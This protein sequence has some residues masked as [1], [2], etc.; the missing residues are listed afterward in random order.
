MMI[1]KV[2]VVNKVVES[3]LVNDLVSSIEMIQDNKN[4]IVVFFDR[5][6][7]NH[8]LVMFKGNSDCYL[9]INNRK[10]DDFNYDSLTLPREKRFTWTYSGGQG[11]LATYRLLAIVDD[12]IKH[13]GMTRES[14]I[15]LEANHKLPRV[16]KIVNSIDNLE[17]CNQVEN[18]RH[19]AAWRKLQCD[20]KLLPIKFSAIDLELV[21]DTLYINTEIYRFDDK[22]VVRRPYE[23][24]SIREYECVPQDDGT[25]QFR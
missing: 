15:G 16:Y 12:I 9:L 8:D 3:G 7:W 13:N 2:Q 1:K 21:S 18:L 4:T 14:Y 17:V 11:S 23:D 24:G 20:D 25:W 19:Y 5:T 22:V 6:R 10:S